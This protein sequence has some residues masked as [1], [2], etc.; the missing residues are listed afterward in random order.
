MMRVRVTIRCSLSGTG[1]SVRVDVDAKVQGG[2]RGRGGFAIV[3][4]AALIETSVLS[5]VA[6]A[7]CVKTVG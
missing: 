2:V 3:V 5:V 7:E 4:E 6:S 1:G